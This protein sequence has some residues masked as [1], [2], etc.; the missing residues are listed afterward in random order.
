M[1]WD[2]I[3]HFLRELLSPMPGAR[4]TVVRIA[5]VALAVGIVA[6]WRGVFVGLRGF[7]WACLGLTVSAILVATLA[8]RIGDRKPAGAER[9]VRFDPFEGFRHAAGSYATRTETANFYGNIALFV[10]LGL[11]LAWLLYG[12]LIGRVIVAWV[13]GAALSAS[14]ELTQS[15]MDRVVD[16]NDIILNSSG[17]VLGAILGCVCLLVTRMWKWA[18]QREPHAADPQPE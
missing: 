8:L 9:E 1:D 13:L 7:L 18:T 16:V 3:E 6:A 14:I 11:L 10:P 2:R 5:A 12:W 4:L 17:A 15:T